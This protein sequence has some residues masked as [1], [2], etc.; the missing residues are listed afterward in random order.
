M[1]ELKD[2]AS[3]QCEQKKKCR[4]CKKPH[5]TA[6]HLYKPVASK[7][8]GQLEDSNGDE[9]EKVTS[10]CV[11][12]CHASNGNPTSSA[13]SALIVPV[14]LHHKDDPEREIQM[15]AVLDD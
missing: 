3:R 13:T 10:N 14:W 8:D 6:L 5:V 12:V 11:S 7:K 9:S 2:Y 1:R 4:I 15:Y